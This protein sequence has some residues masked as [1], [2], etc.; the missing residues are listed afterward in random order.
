MCFVPDGSLYF[1]A[2]SYILLQSWKCSRSRKYHQNQGMMMMIT[3][4]FQE[5]F[6]QS[7]NWWWLMMLIFQDNLCD[8]E[9]YSDDVKV[10]L[11]VKNYWNR[12]G[13]GFDNMVS[14]LIFM[15][16]TITRKFRLCRKRVRQGKFENSE[17]G[18]SLGAWIIYIFVLFERLKHDLICDDVV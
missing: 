9:N 10:T 5:I 2:V 3:V 16:L 4:I 8:Q 18:G 6:W 7:K 17:F 14:I 1:Y 15:I 12:D 11:S 13:D